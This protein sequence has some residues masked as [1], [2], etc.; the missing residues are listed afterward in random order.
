MNGAIPCKMRDCTI[1]ESCKSKEKSINWLLEDDTV[2]LCE[3]S[4][5]FGMSK[6][7]PAGAGAVLICDF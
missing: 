2:F 5:A 3:I 7:V 4:F 1:F 6:A